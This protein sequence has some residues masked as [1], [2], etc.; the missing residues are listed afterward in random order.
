MIRKGIKLYGESQEKSFQELKDKLSSAS[1]LVMPSGAEGYVIYNNM[2]KLGLGC[3]LLQHGRVIAY[4]SREL[5]TY[6]KNYP[7]HN[8]ELA[9]IIFA[10]KI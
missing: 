3:I 8:L 9:A 5:K 4:A 7:T 10:L 2:L 6:E 1:V